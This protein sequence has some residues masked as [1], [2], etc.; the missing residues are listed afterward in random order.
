VTNAWLIRVMWVAVVLLSLVGIATVVARFSFPDDLVLRLQPQRIRV[1]EALGRS[2][3]AAVNRLPELERF[4]RRF[5]A[6]GTLTRWHILSGGL[7]IVLAPLQLAGP[8]RRRFPVLHR[9]SGRFLL[10]IGSVA[11][12]TGLYFGIFLPIAGTAE[13]IIIALVGILFLVAIMRAFRAIRRRDTVR[14]RE[15]ML[16]AF[17]VMVAV[18]ATRVMGA[19][20]DVAF[21]PTGISLAKLFVIDLWVTWALVIGLTEW[22]IRH[23]RLTTRAAVVAERA[24]ATDRPAERPGDR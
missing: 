22:W 13:S 23:T 12:V 3:P 18:P 15:W 16:R 5:A 6:N 2:D 11:A 7:F 14:H 24:L 10:V 8:V 9:W 20:L 1:L 17:G 19:V 4:E 21:A